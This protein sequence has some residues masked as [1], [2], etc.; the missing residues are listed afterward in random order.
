MSASFERRKIRTQE[1]LAAGIEWPLLRR[2]TGQSL[3]EMTNG[4][5]QSSLL[6]EILD[7]RDEHE[8]KARSR[9]ASELR[10]TWPTGAGFIYT[11]VHLAEGSCHEPSAFS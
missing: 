5:T 9:R 2:W 11:P 4:V 3:C 8:C 6:Q 1:E 10:R 7:N